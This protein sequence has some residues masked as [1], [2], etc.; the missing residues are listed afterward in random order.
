M[1]AGHRT[2]EAAALATWTS[3]RGAD[4]RVRRVEVS[5]DRAEVVLD[6]GQCF[7]DWVYCLERSDGWQA[8]VDGNGPCIGWE[9]PTLI[10][11]S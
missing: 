3:T 6:H 8:M 7:D 1:G 4:P 9:D 2:P 11:W 5:G 10:Q